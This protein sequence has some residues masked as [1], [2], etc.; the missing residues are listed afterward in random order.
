MAWNLRDFASG[1][2][3]KIKS[4]PDGSNGE[5]THHHVDSSALPTGAATAAHQLTTHT[6]LGAPSDVEATGNGSFIAILKRIRTLLSNPIAVTGTFWQATQPVSGT[7]GVSGSVSVTGTFFQATQPVSLTA[8]PTLPAGSNNIGDVDV[9]S[10]PAIPAGTNTIGK[11]DH[12]S[13]GIG[14]GLKT[15]TTAG[16]DVA[17]AASTP[18]KWVIIQAQTDNTNS[19]AVGGA[20]V[21]AA[22]ATGTGILLAAGESIPLAIDNLADVFIDALVSGEGVR[23]TYGT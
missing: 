16:T 18:A 3:V 5:V 1:L 12:S 17:L 8:L 15:V 22:V 4:T 6:A 21:D 7:V 13:T 11:V 14:Q 9:A 23:Y 20:G 2:A 10:L 19:I